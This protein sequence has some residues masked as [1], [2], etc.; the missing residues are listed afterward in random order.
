MRW[1]RK[2]KVYFPYVF[3]SYICDVGEHKQFID[4]TS[5]KRLQRND[6][7]EIMIHIFS[8]FVLPFL[9]STVEADQYY[10]CKGDGCEVGSAEIALIVFSLFMFFLILWTCC[11]SCFCASEEELERNVRINEMETGG[12]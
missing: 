7:E 1:V 8:L 10:L 12:W 2:P 11:W 5:S 9:L 3:A 6:I 4:S